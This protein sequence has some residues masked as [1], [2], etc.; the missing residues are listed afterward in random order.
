MQATPCQG[1]GPAPRTFQRGTLVRGAP[2]AAG[3]A[4]LVAPAYRLAATARLRHQQPPPLVSLRMAGARLRIELLGVQHLDG[5]CEPLGKE[6][7][8]AIEI[9]F[10]GLHT[11]PRNDERSPVCLDGLQDVGDVLERRDDGAAIE[12]LG[13]LKPCFGGALL[14]RQ[15]HAVKQRLGGAARD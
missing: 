4:L 6:H 11:A 2:P 9:D 1:N 13:A 15:A 14:L 10:R 3:A 12:G 7:A 8:R 5:A